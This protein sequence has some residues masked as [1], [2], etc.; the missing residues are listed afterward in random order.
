MFLIPFFCS[1]H[2][3]LLWLCLLSVYTSPRIIFFSLCIMY[4]CVFSFFFFFFFFPFFFF[5]FFSLFCFFSL[6]FSL[7][8]LT[9]SF[10]FFFFFKVAFFSFII[11]T[12]VERWVHLGISQGSALGGEWYGLVLIS[13]GAEIPDAIQSVTVARRGYG[14][15][16]VS[17]AIGSQIINILIGLGIEKYLSLL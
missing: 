14:S 16:A 13:I 11:S 8:L 15:M 4:I 1:F 12:V 7:F 10:S 6:S 2:Q 5:L 3:L 9:S 17:N